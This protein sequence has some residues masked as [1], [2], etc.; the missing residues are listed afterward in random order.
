MCSHV[1]TRNSVLRSRILHSR[2]RPIFSVRSPSSPRPFFR[3]GKK[4]GGQY[5]GKRERRGDPF[6]LPTSSSSSSTCNTRLLI[7]LFPSSPTTEVG[8]R[9]R[10]RRRRRRGLWLQRRPT[11]T[12]ACMHR[13]TVYTICIRTRTLLGARPTARNAANAAHLK[14]GRKNEKRETASIS[15]PFFVCTYHSPFLY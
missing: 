15:N 4:R 12:T 8:A 1:H 14:E 3:G 5:Q 10:R 9:R 6:F 7:H 2:L 11:T 13:P